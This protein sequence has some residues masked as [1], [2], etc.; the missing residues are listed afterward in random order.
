MSRRTL[1]GVATVLTVS[2]GAL[3]FAQNP[4]GG[5]GRFGG[6][7][8]AP[9]LPNTPYDGRFTFV[10]LRYGPPSS[11]ASQAIPW[12]HDYPNGER[13]FMQI[14]NEVSY[15]APHTGETNILAFDDPEL[16]KY[17]VAY[18]CEPGPFWEMSDREAAAMRAYLDKGGFLIIDDFRMRHWPYFEEQMKRILPNARIIDVDATSPVFHA[19][20]EVNDL[21]VVQQ[22]YDPGRPIF[23]VI[24]QDNDP[25]KRV[26]VMI[27]YNTDISEYW[28]W[29][30]TGLKPID[31]SNEAYKLGVNYII[32]GL[33][34]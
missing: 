34:H 1:V 21:S 30:D 32:Y 24:Y 25:S 2:A 26:M 13:H 28:E 20:F 3:A 9:I 5:F 8:L 11:Y 18:L 17:P 23:R 27:N 19:F 29:S 6:R 33:T 22:Y 15:L 14:M 31:E 4:F 7:N 16:F 10:R 12:S